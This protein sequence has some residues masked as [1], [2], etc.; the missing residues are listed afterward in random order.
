MARYVVYGCDQMYG[1]LHGMYEMEVIDAD[2]EEEARE[3]AISL[4]FDVI[5][6]Y[7][8]IYNALDEE[9]KEY[10]NDDMTEDEIEEMYDDVYRDD[11]DCYWALVDELVAGQYS[12]EELNKMCNRMSYGHFVRKYCIQ[13]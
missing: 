9:A 6:S 4:A 2:N 7:A 10:I 12:T 5:Q 3:N 1:G 8:E 11:V 13:E